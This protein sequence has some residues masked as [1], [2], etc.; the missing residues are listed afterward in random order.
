MAVASLSL[1]LLQ[2]IS[3]VKTFLRNVRDAPK[4]LE[5]LADLLERLEGILQDVR[6]IMERQSSLQGQ[7]FPTPSMTI[8]K[9]LK[10]CEKT[11]QALQDIV[12]K[13]AAL[14]AQDRSAIARLKDDV[15]LEFKAKDIAAFE[16]RIE[17]EINY[18]YATMGS[19]SASIL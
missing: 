10:S 15:K 3:E 17:R 19:N 11:L 9:C 5:R 2:S 8:F 12:K 6:D 16:T 13:V 4:E 7:H 1:Q 14:Y 18:L